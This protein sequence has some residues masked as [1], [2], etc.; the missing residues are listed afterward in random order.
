MFL[1]ATSVRLLQRYGRCTPRGSGG[2]ADRTIAIVVKAPGGVGLVAASA[3]TNEAQRGVR[4]ISRTHLCAV[5]HRAMVEELDRCCGF[6]GK[7]QH[8]RA[9][10]FLL[11]LQYQL[12]VAVISR[13]RCQCKLHCC[14]ACHKPSIL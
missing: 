4:V 1:T 13:A 6:P 9:V 7:L 2:T 10:T 5:V 8:A 3:E 12:S 11:L 14:C